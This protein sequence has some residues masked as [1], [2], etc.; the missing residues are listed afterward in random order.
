MLVYK[1]IGSEISGID[2]AVWLYPS[3]AHLIYNFC[4]A[5]NY[6]KVPP[7][8]EVRDASEKQPANAS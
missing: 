4:F 6:S 3:I 2:M 7:V 8:P 5:K 1:E